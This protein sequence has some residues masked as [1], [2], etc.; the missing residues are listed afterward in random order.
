M[1]FNI[2]KHRK[3]WF[4]LSGILVAISLAATLIFGLN[5]GLGFTGGARWHVEFNEKIDHFELDKFFEKQGALTQ[6]PQI[7]PAD[8]R[9][10]LITIED[11]P[12]A[13]LQKIEKGIK[14]EIGEFTEISYQKVDAS[15][16]ASFK[17]KAVYA[18]LASLLGIILFVAFAFRKIPAAV[19]PWRFGAVAIIA[20]F[21]DV[22]I[23]LGIF[24]TLGYFLGI[25]LDLQ[26]VTALLATLGFSVN[27][28]IVILD[29]VRENIRSQK[30]KET[31]EDT[32]E[33]SIKQTI[34]RSI[35]TSVSTL[36]PL[37][38][39]L[40]FGADSIFYFVLA[41]TIG[42]LIGTYSSIFLAAPLLVTWKNISD[43]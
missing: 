16:G 35:H 34:L 40:F 38:G 32:I 1:K 21:H 7:Q 14:A 8:E 25:E 4:T 30:A 5:L 20:L 37:L 31:F 18:I 41:L 26:F 22:L 11:L 24:V 28:T 42:I 36:F 19:N 9:Q 17:T 15:I 13:E 29:R 27:D 3:F 43:K 39:L 33:K 6:K 2:T 10:Y 23:I 12:D